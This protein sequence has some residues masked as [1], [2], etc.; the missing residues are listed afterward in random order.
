M[1]H[2]DSNPSHWKLLIF[3]YN[4]DNP[5]LFVSRRTGLAVTL[6]F[7]RPTAWLLSGLALLGIVVVALLNNR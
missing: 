3:Y 4:P 2:T 7:A 1:I 6:N 5:Y